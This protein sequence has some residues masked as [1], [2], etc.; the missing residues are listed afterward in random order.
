MGANVSMEL[1]Q[2]AIRTHVT[3]GL[4]GVRG[5]ADNLIIWGKDR[6][7]HD[8]NLRALL[9][10][11][12]NLGMTIGPDSVEKFRKEEISFFG[13]KVSASGIAIGDE[14]ADALLNAGK[15][16]TASELRRFLGLAVYCMIPN[17]ATLADP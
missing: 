8:Q 9:E 12:R 10:R 14:K 11:L 6:R 16:G 13:L 7:E 17:L 5:I 1:M 3:Q 4:R 15:P 2:Q